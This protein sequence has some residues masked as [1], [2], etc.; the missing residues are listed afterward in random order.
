MANT[1][2]QIPVPTNLRVPGAKYCAVA[3]CVTTGGSGS[4]GRIDPPWVTSE[5]WQGFSGQNSFIEFG[6]KPFVP[7]ETGGIHGEVIYASTRP[8]DDPR[9]LIHTSWTPDV[10]GV[11]INLYQ[12][13][14]AADGSQSLTLVDT[15][16]T[17]SWDDWAQGFNPTSGLPN[18]NCPGQGAATGTNADL[19]FFTLSNQPDYLDVYNNQHNLTP[20]HTV[21]NSSQ[22]KCYDGMHNW[23]QVQPAPYDGFYQFPS[24]TGI[25][26]TNGK[27]LGTNCTGCV[28][29]PDTTD[30]YRFNSPMLPP[31]KYVVE[32]VV[33]PGYELVKEEDKNILIGD[34]YIAPVTQEFGGLGNIFILPDQAA[35]GASYNANNAQNPTTDLGTLHLPRGEGDTGSVEIFWPCVGASR[36]VPDYISLFPQS[37]EVAPFAGATRNLCD[38]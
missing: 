3:D 2:E 37:L 36:I 7:G 38:R 8:F 1:A 34:N 27:P 31:G 35:I 22:F 15:T 9:L 26:P 29:N 10:P 18:M 30:P 28:S 14:T 13:G 11:T 19:F 23:N 16:K 25:N 21:P 17:S 12:E 32:V 20:L 33:P 6:K 4:T 24:V 5:G